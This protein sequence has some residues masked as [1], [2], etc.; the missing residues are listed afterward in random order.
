M[1]GTIQKSVSNIFWAFLSFGATKLLN[2]VAI[3]VLARL[4]SPNEMGLM[5]LCLVVMAYFEILSRFGLGAALISSGQI[6][7]DVT[8]TSNAVFFLSM[9]FASLM[10]LLAFASAGALAG[11]F[12]QPMLAPMLKVLCIAMLIEALGTVNNALLQK[13]LQFKQKIIPDTMRGLIKAIV[14]ISLA[15]AGFG[16]WSLVFGY[17][18]GAVVFCLA[19]W[20]VRPWR[21][22][23]VPTWTT[24]RPVLRYGLAL[25][26]AE[27]VNSL[28]RN[29]P[30]LLIG[31]LLGASALGVF[32]LAYRIPELAI[33]SFSLVASTVTHPIMAEMRDDNHSLREYFYACLRYF[34]LL[35]FPGGVAIAVVSPAL[36]VVLYSPVWYDMIRPMQFLSIAFALATVNILPGAIYKAIS[37]TELMLRVSLINLPI[38]VIAF[39]VAVNYGLT[40]VAVTEMCVAV[41]A[42]LPNLI[43]LRRCIGI[44]FRQSASC[45]LPGIVC[46]ASTAA[47]GS[48]GYFLFDTAPAQLCASLGLMAVG[49]LAALAVVAP[50]MLSV[51]LIAVRKRRGPA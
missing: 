12:E 18:A 9:V 8:D 48:L 14:S 47:F 46:A 25:I 2:L 29:L 50:E 33:R 6:E 36:V 39:S 24:C 31:K 37:R 28:N 32:N 26:G 49:Y 43:I 41:V 23:A 5:A 16:V 40:A 20:W 44:S 27:T 45:V 4:L 30:M 1:S 13:G 51:A 19:L 11:F 38:T 7:Q 3:I 10:A 21:P 35:T 22:D 15:F 34:S 17:L 42:F